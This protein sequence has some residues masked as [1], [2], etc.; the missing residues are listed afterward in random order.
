MPSTWSRSIG[1]F[2][3]TS[4]LCRWTTAKTFELL[5]TGETMGVFQLEGSGMRRY[6][7]ELKPTEVRDLAAMVALFR[8]GPMANIPAYIRRK[9][10]E[11]PVTYLHDSLEPALRDTYGIFVYQEDIM[12]A[13]IAMADYTGPEADNLCYAIR[14]KKEDVL[15]QHEAKFK[16]G[17]KKKGIPPHIVDKVFHEFEPFARYGFNKAHATCYGLIAYQTAYLKA[18]YPIEF[19]TAVMNGFRE[20]AEKVAAVIAEC[21]RLGIEVRPPDVQKSS[22]LFTVETDASGAPEAIR[23][24]LAAIKNVGEGAIEAIVAVR[25]GGE[26]P[27]PFRSLADLCQRV[28]LRT[29]NKRVMESLIKAN[30]VASL[31]TAGAL[32][33]ALDVALENGQRHQRDVAAGQ[34]TLFD[35]FAVPDGRIGP[36]PGWRGGDSAS[37]A[38]ALGEG[39]HRS[40]PVGAPVGRHRGRAAGLRDRLHRRAGGGGRPGQG[41]ARRDPDLVAPGGDPRGLDHARGDARGPPGI[42]RGRRLPEGLRAD[43]HLL[44]R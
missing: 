31:G 43:R 30:A 23:F 13:A 21:R 14:K 7:K 3:W 1:A 40:L 36:V 32:L 15:R 34:S 28:D 33:A 6:V 16:A 37:G 41:H 29:V 17:A 42:G 18:N 24:G 8:P 35:L 39:A 12:T 5:S 10:G 27:G 26:E 44:G 11:E 22:A 4:T 38:A 19:M 25:D 2:A 20:R 9:H